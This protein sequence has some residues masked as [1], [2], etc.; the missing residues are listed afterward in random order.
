[1]R[2]QSSVSVSV[3]THPQQHPQPPGCTSVDPAQGLLS[4]LAET[5]SNFITYSS[6]S[7]RMEIPH[8]PFSA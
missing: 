1:M 5:V 8:F 7:L 3:G 6:F 2:V 4:F